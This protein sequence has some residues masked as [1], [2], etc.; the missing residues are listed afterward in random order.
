M[1]LHKKNHSRFGLLLQ[2]IAMEIQ[3]TTEP[4]AYTLNRLL[5]KILF[6]VQLIGIAGVCLATYGT[7]YLNGYNVEDCYKG[8]V[9]NLGTVYNHNYHTDRTYNKFYNNNVTFKAGFTIAGL[10]IVVGAL[11]KIYLMGQIWKLSCLVKFNT[12]SFIAGAICLI[13]MSWIPYDSPDTDYDHNLYHMIFAVCGITAIV[14][15]QILDA[16]YW[17]SY[18][19][20]KQINHGYI[21][22][23]LHSYSFLC[24]LLS[25]IFY[26]GNALEIIL[27]YKYGQWIGVLF[28]TLGFISPT[29]HSIFI[30]LHLKQAD[31][32]DIP[33][34]IG[35]EIIATTLEMESTN[36]LS[37]NPQNN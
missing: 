14:V 6:V 11:I 33:Q 28:I 34:N 15:T 24:P 9:S 30:H 16:I 1:K 3:H 32:I 12:I 10:C 22:Y 2:Y 20:Y 27:E 35:F 21:C 25:I 23:L 4:R 17:F 37:S 5:A 19:Q 31:Q 7:I 29:I 26:G 13:L 8:Y 36:A 18:M